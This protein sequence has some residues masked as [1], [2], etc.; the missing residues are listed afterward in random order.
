[1]YFREDG[2]EKNQN[3]ASNDYVDNVQKNKICFNY[4]FHYKF[5]TY[6]HIILAIT[7]IIINTIFSL[8]IEPMVDRIGFHKRTNAVLTKAQLIVMCYILD[9]WL[10]PIMVGLNLSEYGFSEFKGNFT[11]FGEGW[12]AQVGQHIFMSML[13]FSLQPI[14]DFLVEYL[15]IHLTRYFSG[16]SSAKKG[17]TD[18]LKIIEQQAGPIYYFHYKAAITKLSIALIILMGCCMPAFFLLGILA[19]SIQYIM[20]RLTLCY[21]YRLP[22]M[23]SEF[24]TLQTLDFMKYLP[25]I[26]LTMLFWQFTNKQFF[27]NSIDPIDN[28]D[29]V[30]LSHHLPWQIEWSKL[31]SSQQALLV[32]IPVLLFVALLVDIIEYWDEVRAQNKKN[33]MIFSEQKLPNFFDTLREQDIIDFLQDQQDL[34]EVGYQPFTQQAIDSFNKELAERETGQNIVKGGTSC[35]KENYYMIGDPRFQA[36]CCIDYQLA[37][38]TTQPEDMK[39]IKYL[40]NLPN[41]PPS[42]I[43]NIK[44]EY[45]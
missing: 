15:T 13:I 23:Y 20:D 21:F 40:L 10:L 35:V 3:V 8:I 18:K 27:G 41:L 14:I 31:T 39:Q 37:F 5:S 9:M 19:L 44:L 2:I 42:E 16:G 12:Y 1:M 6:F 43:N 28:I 32:T 17:T 33:Q 24:L 25:P 29:E 26:S 4:I 45:N 11:D 7:I 38:N 36:Y 30:R 22:P 34:S